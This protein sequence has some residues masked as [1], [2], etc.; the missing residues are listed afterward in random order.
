MTSNNLHVNSQHGYKAG[1]STET[2]LVKFMNDVLVA[3]DKNRGVVVLLVDLSSAFDT[4]QH[5]ILMR[6]LEKSLHIRG[7]ALKWFQ[8]F[9]TG[10][11]QAVVVNGVE[12]EW[13]SVTCGV[14]Q[15]SVLGPIL[16][17]IYCRFTHCVFEE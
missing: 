3:V 13:L 17:N 5:D 1:H 12:S 8:S 7:T 16:F 14:P 10:R 6:I 11:T 2:L 4:V 9:L 15:G